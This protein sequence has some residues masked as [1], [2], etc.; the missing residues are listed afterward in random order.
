[1]D[2][3]PHRPGDPRD[4]DVPARRSPGPTSGGTP[5]DLISELYDQLR[6]LARAKLA[7]L[8]KGHTLQPTALVN[9]VYLKMMSGSS[10]GQ[11]FASKA[12]FF[13]AAARSMRNILVDHARAKLSLKRGGGQHKS[14]LYEEA[15]G[16][17]DAPDRI[18]ALH[19]L[20]A[21]L[22]KHDERKASIVSMRFFAGLTHDE[23]A[24]ILGTSVRTVER[25]W[26][27]A[28]AW[29]HK[30]WEEESHEPGDSGGFNP[31]PSNGPGCE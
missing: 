17:D 14:E 21:D 10:G 19:E 25:E 8:P 18:I 16:F 22:E 23:I 13:A 1:M 24:G 27:F 15:V 2:S 4:P 9:E 11:T 20:I 29:M 5:Q 26:R 3:T 30:R 12:E 31:S 7:L 6:A 28:R